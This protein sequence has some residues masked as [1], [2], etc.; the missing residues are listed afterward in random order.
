VY[1]K[2]E[3][4]EN[5]M[6]VTTMTRTVCD[7]EIPMSHIDLSNTKSQYRIVVVGNFNGS[8]K[9]EHRTFSEEEFEEYGLGI[10]L[11]LQ[12]FYWKRSP[13]SIDQEDY[14]LLP[15]DIQR[16]IPRKKGF[17]PERI[18]VSCEYVVSSPYSTIT[19]LPNLNK[20][21]KVD[22]K[23]II[24]KYLERLDLNVEP[25]CKEFF[26]FIGVTK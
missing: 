26:E 22:Q 10:A 11:I 1:Q 16:L 2:I 17:F 6:A 23:R 25:Y 9:K 15:V 3:R 12:N 14:Q 5:T 20:I 4:K 7:V 13:Y 8:S 18:W 21:P 24:R 19:Y